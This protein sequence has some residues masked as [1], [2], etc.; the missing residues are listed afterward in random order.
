[1]AVL[2]G[3]GDGTFQPEVNYS[4]P[5]LGAVAGDFNGDGN[6]DLAVDGVS[7]LL[8]IG[9]GAFQ[10]PADASPGLVATLRCDKMRHYAT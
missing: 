2:L 1:V 9:K 5:A 6:L 10:Q 3:N 7:I 4:A 8:D